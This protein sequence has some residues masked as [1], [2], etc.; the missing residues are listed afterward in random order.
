MQNPVLASTLN[1]SNHSKSGIRKTLKQ[2]KGMT[3]FLFAMRRIAIFNTT[4]KNNKALQAY[5]AIKLALATYNGKSDQLTMLG[6][7]LCNGFGIS[8]EKTIIANKSFMKKFDLVE[9]HSSRAISPMFLYQH[10]NSFAQWVVLYDIM[11]LAPLRNIKNAD[12]HP[13]DGINALKDSL[14][15]NGAH[16]FMGKFSSWCYSEKPKQFISETTSNRH[17]FFFN[18]HAYLGETKPFTHGIIV[19][20]IKTVNRKEM[21][22]F[23]D[24]NHSSKEGRPEK[25]YM[26]SYET[27]MQRLTDKQGY[28]VDRDECAREMTF[29]MINSCPEKLYGSK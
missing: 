9:A 16:F 6:K 25:I 3:C 24:P 27:F 26:L 17:I 23:R 4:D 7:K 15:K 13:R 21:V 22:F 20:K 11:V 1:A 18:K 8:I 19:D 14:K 2:Q 12:W 10:F 5:K 28:R 29:G